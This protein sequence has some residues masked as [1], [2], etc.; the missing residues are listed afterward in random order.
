MPVAVGLGRG[1]TARC[2]LSRSHRPKLAK[3]WSS[4]SSQQC[5]SCLRVGRVCLV[6]KRCQRKP[7]AS[8]GSLSSRRRLCWLFQRQRRSERASWDM[9]RNTGWSNG[10]T[11]LYERAAIWRIRK[12]ATTAE[13]QEIH[14]APSRV[15][16]WL[17]IGRQVWAYSRTSPRARVDVLGYWLVS[18]LI[19]L[20]TAM[21]SI[22]TDGPPSLP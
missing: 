22:S 17:R 1:T 8:S 3:G 6:V 5:L 21:L 19:V 15:R 10:F 4:P 14:R 7:K 16:V 20:C 13:K 2:R 18:L 9:L 11:R 12:E